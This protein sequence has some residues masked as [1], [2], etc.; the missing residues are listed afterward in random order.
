MTSSKTGSNVVGSHPR[1]QNWSLITNWQPGHDMKKNPATKWELYDETVAVGAVPSLTAHE[2]EPKGQNIAWVG[3]AGFAL[4]VFRRTGRESGIT[5]DRR[6]MYNC[7]TWEDW[8]LMYAKDLQR[9][10]ALLKRDVERFRQKPLFMGTIK[11]RHEPLASKNAEMF[12]CVKAFSQP[13][14]NV[15]VPSGA[16]ERIDW[17]NDPTDYWN[18]G[19]LIQIWNKAS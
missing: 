18:N 8:G 1:T 7:K 14:K 10:W 19:L 9:L 6:L 4:P 13:P 5:P 17:R 2:D 12:S 11:I 16:I 15:Y 3:N